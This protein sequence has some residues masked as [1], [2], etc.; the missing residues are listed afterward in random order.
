MRIKNIF[1]ISL[2]TVIIAA[3]SPSAD[4]GIKY[5]GS[6]HSAPISAS[7][8]QMQGFI[9]IVHDNGPNYVVTHYFLKRQVFGDHLIGPTNK[10]KGV[11]TLKDGKLIGGPL[12]AITM[13]I[14]ANGVL[15][16]ENMEYRK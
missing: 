11:Y 8:P 16:D 14:D 10:I 4:D 9:E 3:C 15:I 5:V 13:Y 7:G 12:S 6:W 1:I 2:L